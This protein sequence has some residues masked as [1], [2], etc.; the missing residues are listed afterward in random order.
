MEKLR[1][2]SPMATSLLSYL[3]TWLLP[4]AYLARLDRPIGWELLLWPCLWSILLASPSFT[5]LLQLTLCFALGSISMRGAGCTYNDIIDIDIDS[6][7]ARTASRPLAS[8]VVSLRSAYIFLFFQLFLGLLSLLFLMSLSPSPIFTFAI[9]CLSLLLVLVYPF[10]KR[11]T[12]WPQ[13]FLGLSFSWGSLMGIVVV[14]GILPNYL[15][16]FYLG[17]VCWVIGYDTIYAHQDTD[18]DSLLGLGSTALLFGERTWL[19]LLFFYSST[20]SLFALTFYLLGVGLFGYLGLFLCMV[21]LLYQVF[22]LDI[23]D[24]YRCHRLFCS[25]RYFGLFLFCGLLLDV[26]I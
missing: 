26:L 20:I 25:N 1:D 5:L 19:Y 13:L 3:P 4:Y 10:M 24:T 15:F 21:N 12:F 11:I 17:C 23:S 6:Q 8:G 7:V 9:A 18:D 16:L 14:D 22:S 2:S